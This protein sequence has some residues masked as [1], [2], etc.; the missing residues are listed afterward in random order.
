M[1]N[2]KSHNEIEQ[3]IY[4]DA[5]LVLLILVLSLFLCLIILK[6]PEEMIE[7]TISKECKHEWHELYTYYGMYSTEKFVDT[8][9]PKCKSEKT[10]SDREWKILK[11]DEEY[12]ENRYGN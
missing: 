12:K 1:I 8:Y 11:L 6:E 10:F 9:C 3:K 2:N 4:K 5:F 7:D